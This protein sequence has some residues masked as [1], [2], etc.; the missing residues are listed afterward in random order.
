LALTGGLWTVAEIAAD[1]LGVLG[2]LVVGIFVAS[3]LDSLVIYRA[4]GSDKTGSA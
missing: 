2:Y 4:V 1:H 3:W